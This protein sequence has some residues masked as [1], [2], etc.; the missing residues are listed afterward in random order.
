MKKI[1]TDE[2]STNP[3]YGVFDFAR[4]S[5]DRQGMKKIKTER[6][7]MKRIIKNGI[8]FVIA[9][10]SIT[11]CMSVSDSASIEALSENESPAVEITL[12]DPQSVADALRQLEEIK[13]FYQRV[14]DENARKPIWS[15]EK[16][17]KEYIY[18]IEHIESKLQQIYDVQV[19]KDAYVLQETI[20]RVIRGFP[21]TRDNPKVLGIILRRKNDFFRWKYE[22]G[23]NIATH[24]RRYEEIYAKLVDKFVQE[25][26]RDDIKTATNFYKA[27]KGVFNDNEDIIAKGV[28]YT[29]RVANCK[30]PI[31]DPIKMDAAK[32]HNCIVSELS[33]SQYRAAKEISLAPYEQM[34]NYPKYNK[35][36]FVNKEIFNQAQ[37]YELNQKE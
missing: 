5:C 16:D 17:L 36:D 7:I 26:V 10:I 8:L 21:D 37:Q 34:P 2:S 14:S 24:E 12:S 30:R 3:I 31:P 15:H 18:A 23:A 35:R 33:S 20:D 29:M 11:G 22:L 13:N 6:N 25:R 28:P 19:Y 32:I 4:K 27:G 1:K 9:A